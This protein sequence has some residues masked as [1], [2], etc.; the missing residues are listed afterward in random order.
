MHIQYVLNCLT[1]HKLDEKGILVPCFFLQLNYMSISVIYFFVVQ[2]LI[3]LSV[4]LGGIAIVI[5]LLLFIRIWTWN[6]EQSFF[7]HTEEILYNKIQFCK[8]SNIDRRSVNYNSYIKID[9]S[10]LILSQYMMNK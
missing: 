2:F 5:F 6:C 8:Q 1:I 4:E 7:F 10:F 3:E 9:R